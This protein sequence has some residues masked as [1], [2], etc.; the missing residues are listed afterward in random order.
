MSGFVALVLSIFC[1]AFE[2]PLQ[3]LP[4]PDSGVLN[5]VFDVVHAVSF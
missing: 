5:V 3:P 1:A 2:L 4:N